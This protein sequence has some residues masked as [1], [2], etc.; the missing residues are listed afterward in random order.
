MVGSMVRVYLS[1]QLTIE[2]ADRRIEA[3]A[4]PGRQGREAFAFLAMA[5]GMPVSRPAL[6]E[7]LWGSSAPASA[8]ASLNSIIS[9]LRRLLGT[10]GL[11][12]PQVLRFV[13]GC[14]EL[15]FPADTWIDH[16]AAFDAIH[17]AETAL[18]AGDPRAAYAPSAIARQICGRPF[19][20]GSETE[21]VDARR[22]KLHRT[23]L[24]A[25]E[26]RARVYLATGEHELAAEVARE[27]IQ[28]APL[29]ESARRLLMEAY[30]RSGNAAEALQAYEDCRAAIAEALGVSPSEETKRLKGEILQG[31]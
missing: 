26:C 4:F 13:G 23:L 15:R 7:A 3:P 25:L 16:P 31:L 11:S 8:D 28:L 22:T 18:R 12:G 5:G 14:F 30:A 29:R 27:T 17:K 6:L 9:K 1:G 2:S 10:V 24:R 19:L 20:P 21:W